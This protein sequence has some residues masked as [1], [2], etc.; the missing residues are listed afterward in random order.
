MSTRFFVLCSFLL[1]LFFVHAAPP[2]RTDFVGT[3]EGVS[4]RK[5]LAGQ[6]FIVELNI[7]QRDGIY[8][9]DCHMNDTNREE[10]MDRTSNTRSHWTGTG[11]MDHGSLN[12]TFK[13]DFGEPSKGTLRR[14]GGVLILTLG[15]VRYRVH[16][17][18]Q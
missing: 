11:S 7:T 13:S 12:F 4:L 17:S 10:G 8:S 5:S 16:F 3:Y 18:K 1:P 2:P 6:S 9:L 14:D 15:G